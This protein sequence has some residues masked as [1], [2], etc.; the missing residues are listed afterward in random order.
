MISDMIDLEP[1]LGRYESET[2]LVGPLL[3]LSMNSS[4][5]YFHVAGKGAKIYN[6][7]SLGFVENESDAQKL[8]ADAIVK[9]KSRFADVVTFGS[10][11]EMAHAVHE[12]WQCEETARV[13]SS[14]A[15][16]TR[17]EP[18]KFVDDHAATNGDEERIPLDQTSKRILG[19]LAR[20]LSEHHR[21]DEDPP[22]Q[23]SASTS[24][25]DVSPAEQQRHFGLSPDDVTG[26]SAATRAAAEAPAVA[27]VTTNPLASTAPT[28]KPE[29]INVAGHETLNGMRCRS[30]PSDGHEQIVSVLA[31]ELLHHA[32]SDE[33]RPIELPPATGLP[34]I[35][36]NLE[37]DPSAGRQYGAFELTRDE[38]AAAFLDL[39]SASPSDGLPIALTEAEL[40]QPGVITDLPAEL[41][42]SQADGVAIPPVKH[43]R[44]LTAKILRF[45]A[46]GAATI[47]V[48][49]LLPSGTRQGV[50]ESLPVAAIH[51]PPVSK[52]G[53]D[54]TQ[55]AA[56]APASSKASAALLQADVAPGAV[57]SSSA[58]HQRAVEGTAATAAVISG[59]RAPAATASLAASRQREHP[60]EMEDTR[61]SS[62]PAS[63]RDA[64]AGAPSTIASPSS[65][66]A[67]ES[68]KTAI[69]P[70]SGEHAPGAAPTAVASLPAARPLQTE[71]TKTA[72][73]HASGQHAPGAAP[74]TV[75]SSPAA[76]LPETES[77]KTA[78]ASASG[79]RAPE[80]SPSTGASSL[81]V[82][83]SQTE[84][85]NTAV[86]S[87]SRQHA[88][89][90]APSTGASLPV[91]QPSLTEST[92]AAVT[93][94]SGKSAPEAVP[95]TVAPLPAAQPSQTEST[96]AAVTPP[97]GKSAPEAVPSTVASLPAAQPSQT[98]STKG[99]VAPVSGKPTPTAAPSTVAS[100]PAA[101]LSEV[102]RS[103]AAI[104]PVSG[105]AA[106]QVG[107]ATRPDTD[108]IAKLVSRGMQSLKS[109]D[110][111]SA[112]LS[113]RRAAEAISGPLTTPSISIERRN[114]AAPTEASHAGG[115]SRPDQST[116][117]AQET[118]QQ[119]VPLPATATVSK[120]SPPPYVATVDAR[121]P[122]VSG[123]TT[124]AQKDGTTRR[125]DPVEVATLLKR[126]TDSLKNGDFAT[127]RLSLRRAAEGGNA[128]AALALGSTYD[129]LVLQQL[130]A[131]GIAPD[132][133]RARQWYQKAADLGSDAAAQRLAKLAQTGQ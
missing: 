107:T 10:H 81:A 34:P 94:T 75:A 133:V 27:N 40:G 11:T 100:P 19:V 120:A 44:A 61:A 31:R 43:T 46:L 17:A 129:P 16:A 102:K 98:E 86:A 124:P 131:I 23:S 110:L 115:I 20:E 49:T 71:G 93:S 54:N 87:I 37:N 28:P 79:P 56:A 51:H 1:L 90:A 58:P 32:R 45:A 69:A 60:S 5:R 50:R 108:E 66:P 21:R 35:L 116:T 26:E 3:S 112:R 80:A 130:G 4:Y 64:L 70:D 77:T 126:G 88:P 38:I 97:S 111:E 76:Q 74:S 113:L 121:S 25:S 73:A 15:I 132:V 127:A 30:E 52:N 83:P 119:T 2:I 109:G 67:R 105:Q 106:Q 92:K 123:Q 47:L 99:T 48:W 33:Q 39:K 36:T 72:V 89:E 96:K 95:S 12:R 59:Q 68:R 122:P 42:A 6:F 65:A 117:P 18:S 118:S 101:Q 24:T 41:T 104:A 91:A 78:V 55:S 57:A 103:S 63:A 125:L 82:L 13:L 29:P 8:R 7:L 62:A 22:V 84:S 85:T 128:D 9:F 114:D 53:S 14:A